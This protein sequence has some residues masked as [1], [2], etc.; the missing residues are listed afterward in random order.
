MIKYLTLNFLFFNSFLLANENFDYLLK[1]LNG[2]AVYEAK[3]PFQGKADLVY[4]VPQNINW[5]PPNT[6]RATTSTKKQLI[7]Y[8][9]V[10]KNITTRNYIDINSE[11]IFTEIIGTVKDDK[12]QV[13]I[14]PFQGKS[15]IFEFSIQ[16]FIKKMNA[17]I[18]Y[19]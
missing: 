11:V 4:Y 16:H 7:L 18:V 10:S 5:I 17:C 8:Y 12:V 6:F 9:K 14:E 15:T 19:K 2:I 3:N 1:H 13:V